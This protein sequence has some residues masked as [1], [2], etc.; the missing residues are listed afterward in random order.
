[1]CT[2]VESLIS[3]MKIS[4]SD[5]LY[6]KMERYCHFQE[7]C[8]SEVLLRWKAEGG[9]P[10]VAEEVVKLLEESG[11][12][13]EQRFALAFARGKARING[14]G[15]YKVSYLLQQKRVERECI[16]RAISE[17]AEAFDS[18]LNSALEKKLRTFRQSAGP[19]EWSGLRRYL[20]QKGFDRERIEE[21]L[22]RR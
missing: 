10:E 4:K 1:M 15:P 14:W 13:D 22:K 9:E 16:D 6:L 17:N 3:L 11:V 5:P 8:R 7:R 20:A 19:A 21:A 18:A 12:L 2:F